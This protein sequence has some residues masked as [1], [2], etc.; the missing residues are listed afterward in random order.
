MFNFFKGEKKKEDKPKVDMRILPSDVRYALKYKEAILTKSEI[1]DLNMNH[2][3][4]E[5]LYLTVKGLQDKPEEQRILLEKYILHTLNKTG[6][7]DIDKK[8][9]QSII[10]DSLKGN[11]SITVQGE[12]IAQISRQGFDFWQ[13]KFKN[14]ARELS[15][16][17]RNVFLVA[18][19]MILGLSP[20]VEEFSKKGKTLHIIIPKWIDEGAHTI[21]YAV[22]FE[23]KEPKVEFLLKNTDKDQALAVLV[24]DATNS[25]TVFE[26]I[27]NYWK[28]N[29]LQEPDTVAMA[30]LK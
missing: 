27:K 24:D 7:K 15:E 20:F 23:G 21:G 29:G 1:E 10:S 4:N 8:V 9:L 22:K 11:D 19:A 18:N 14:K 5:A 12:K 13:E 6:T 30:N 16:D 2:F 28:K 17:K 3:E 25:G 26:K